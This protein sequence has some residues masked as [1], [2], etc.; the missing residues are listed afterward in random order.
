MTTRPSPE[1]VQKLPVWAQDYIAWLR[2]QLSFAE[3]EASMN[4]VSLKT[5]Q[6]AAQTLFSALN[7]KAPVTLMEMHTI[8]GGS[9]TNLMSLLG[10]L[11][12]KK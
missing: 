2:E 5:M 4:A 7:E 6:G 8:A 3:A 11:P 9:Y 12:E 10:P 1:R